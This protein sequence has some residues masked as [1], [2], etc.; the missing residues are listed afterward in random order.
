MKALA[1][2]ALGLHWRDPWL[3]HEVML[4]LG[5]GYVMAAA[6]GAA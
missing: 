3:L 6:T 5:Y 4:W 1:A 2:T